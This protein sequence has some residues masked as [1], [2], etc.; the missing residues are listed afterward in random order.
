MNQSVEQKM[1]LR[2]DELIRRYQSGD[3]SAFS[4]LVTRHDRKV[5]SIA[6]RF[7]RC[8]EDAKDIY[9]EVF[10]RVYKGLDRFRFRSEFSTW[11]YRVT[12][13]VC[14]MYRAVRKRNTLLSL[15]SGGGDEV[16]PSYKKGEDTGIDILRRKEISRRIASALETLSPKQRMVFTLKHYEGQKI[17]EI[18]EFMNCTEGTIKRYLFTAIDRLREQLQDIV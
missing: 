14:I 17:R 5:L 18:A 10:Y 12:I 9:Q 1:E 11:L 13:N 7:T 3:A 15:D 6:A 8:P 2:D 4:A 16:N